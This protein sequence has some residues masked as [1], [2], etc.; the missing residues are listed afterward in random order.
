MSDTYAV[1][2]GE[3]PDEMVLIA[4]G[5]SDTSLPLPESLVYGTTYYWRVD[6]ANEYGG[7]TGDVWSFTALVFD[8]PAGGPTK[9]R[10]I[11]CADDRF[12][13]EDI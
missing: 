5:I 4:S 11:A 7:T 1:Y 6:A 9:R 3:A 8:P 2:F 10:L 13:Y 12:W